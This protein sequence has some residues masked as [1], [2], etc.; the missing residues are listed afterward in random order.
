MEVVRDELNVKAFD[1]VQDPKALVTY[2]VL[3]DNKLLGPKYG[4]RF[5]AVRK[6]LAALDPGEVAGKALA[7]ETVQ[8]EVDGQVEELN[9]NEVLVQTQPVAGLA[10][11][12]DKLITVAVEA[13]ITPELHREGLARE[14]VRRIQDMRKKAGFNIEDRIQTYYVASGEMADVFQA[15][16]GYIQAETLSTEL[17]GAD[18]PGDAEGRAE[19][20]IDGMALSLGVR[21]R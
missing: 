15:W 21:R 1:F 12:A 9:P 13:V 16:G 20:E 4:S 11:A 5:P 10:V 8:L 7:G 14:L 18:I 17:V 3:P 6:A 2:Q 19:L